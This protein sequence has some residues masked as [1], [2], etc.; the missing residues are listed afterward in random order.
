MRKLKV[1]LRPRPTAPKLRDAGE[2]TRVL[3]VVAGDVGGGEDG[4]GEDGGGVDGGGGEDGGGE[5]GGDVEG[6]T[7]FE[8]LEA[9]PAPTELVATTTKL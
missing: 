3:E 6:V 7:E 4:G 5:D 1:A 9:G 2:T 8:A